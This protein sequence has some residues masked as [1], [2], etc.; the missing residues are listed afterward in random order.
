MK[1]KEEGITLIG[2]IVMIIILVILAG[3]T[4]R[5]LTGNGGIVTEAET[6]AVEYKI[7]GYREQIEQ[8]VRSIIVAGGVLGKKV[9]TYDIAEGLREE[10]TWVKSAEVVDR[11]YRGRRIHMG[12]SNRR[13]CISGIL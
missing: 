6:A 9:T 8:K 3:I 10:T 1:K 5:G 7:A 12:N 11:K 4:I 2:L 13:I